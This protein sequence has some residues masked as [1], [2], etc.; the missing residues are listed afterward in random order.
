MYIPVEFPVFFFT[1]LLKE[2]GKRGDRWV[3]WAAHRW[4][5]ASL[6]GD[7]LCYTVA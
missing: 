4:H 6:G 7:V 3:P 5:L 2:M 1:F